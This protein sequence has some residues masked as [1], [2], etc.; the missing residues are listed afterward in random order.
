[1]CGACNDL[2]EYDARH[3]ATEP[4]PKCDVCGLE[5][6]EEDSAIVEDMRICEECSAEIEAKTVH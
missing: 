5:V 6:H 1:M 4:M 2:D 3:G